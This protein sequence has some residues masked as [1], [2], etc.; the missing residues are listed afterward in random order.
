MLPNWYGISDID[1][2]YR[3]SIDDPLIHY[4]GRTFSASAIE[5]SI[6]D[7]FVDETGITNDGI[8]WENYIRDKAI[9]YLDDI[10]DLCENQ[11]IAPTHILS[12]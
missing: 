12:S 11:A 8:E 4:K 6:W 10:V 7:S 3:G 2:E 1:F 9:S 5:D